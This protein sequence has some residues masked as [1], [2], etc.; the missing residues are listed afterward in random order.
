MKLVREHINEK[1]KEES[2]PVH[3]LGIGMEAMLK[4]FKDMLYERGLIS[5]SR[6]VLDNALLVYA[7][8]Y[9]E[10]E[11]VKYLVKE[12]YCDIHVANEYPLRH[13]AFY[14]RYDVVEY[15][16]SIGKFDLNMQYEQ[17]IKWAEDAGHTRIVNLL[18]NYKKNKDK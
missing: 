8:E 14:N 3:D 2:D 7:A 9:G 4:N 18:Y 15:L 17:A 10:L 16:L 13:A 11:L 5:S 1:F 6:D 12:K